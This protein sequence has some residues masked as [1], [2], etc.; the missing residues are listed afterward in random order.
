LP[1]HKLD[2]QAHTHLPTSVD[3]QKIPEVML[4]N[5][6]SRRE[7]Q[8]HFLSSEASSDPGTVVTEAVEQKGISNQNR[9]KLQAAG[10]QRVVDMMVAA[11]E[12][13]IKKK[14]KKAGRG[15]PLE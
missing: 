15:K 3:A 10:E 6:D 11:D 7:V 1:I 8:N 2:A 14:L 12:Q 9:A 13:R 4:L 5:Q